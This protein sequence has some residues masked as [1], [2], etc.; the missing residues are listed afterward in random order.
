[1]TKQMITGFKEAAA[2]LLPQPDA[3][4]SVVGG[5]PTALYLI[6]NAQG[7]TAAITNYGGRLVGLVVPDKDGNPV[8]VVTGPGSLA[9]Y[10]EGPEYYLGAIIGRVG[11][12]I[13][14]AKF[15]LDG[16]TYTLY[17]N[18][19]ANSLHGGKKGFESA[20]WDAEQPDESTLV[21]TLRSPDGDEGYPGNLDVKVTYRITESNGLSISYE[22]QTDQRTPVNLTN[23]AY[24][25][26]NGEGAGLINDHLLQIEASRFTP[27]DEAL[28]PTGELRPVENT[29]FDFRELTPIGSRLHEADDQLTYGGGYDHNFALDSGKA[30]ALAAVAVGD[31]SGI[32][33]EV[34]TD[35]PGIQFYG[36]NAIPEG[37]VLKHGS[38]SEYRTA[39]C[40]ETQYF[41]DAV[42]QPEFDSIILN[43]G[44][45]QKS[46]T[47]YQFSN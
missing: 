37:L 22:A 31:Q 19:G 2:G 12:R 4:K 18:N 34:H 11:N 33:M 44:E 46:E 36:G 43:P 32:R 9:G 47:R 5:K 45:I 20:V 24:F 28:I 17:A 16:T 30:Y 27:V 1:M 10:T 3:F 7:M 26:L 23:H 29:P 25:N 13:A 42:N 41:P 14:G 40:L 21:L 15:D 38:S 35:M 6:H 39:F 8:D